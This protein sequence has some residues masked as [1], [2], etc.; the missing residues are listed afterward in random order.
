MARKGKPDLDAVDRQLAR[1]QRSNDEQQLRDRF[2]AAALTGLANRLSDVV[3]GT[4]VEHI[5]DAAYR[6]ADAML[7]ARQRG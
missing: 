6:L 3:G 5:A 7:E 2:A 1:P 4:T